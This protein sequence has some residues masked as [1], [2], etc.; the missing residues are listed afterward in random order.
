MR[1]LVQICEKS[2]FGKEENKSEALSGAAVWF[3]P[4]CTKQ[5]TH[6]EA[7]LPGSSQA[8]LFSAD[9]PFKHRHE[10]IAHSEQVYQN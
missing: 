8:V 6:K 2:K 9:Y 5:L 4:S 1:A 10:H 7:S 3:M